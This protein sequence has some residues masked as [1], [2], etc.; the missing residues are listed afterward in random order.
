MSELAIILKQMQKSLE[1]IEQ[2]VGDEM[3]PMTREQFAQWANVSERTVDRWRK[4]GLRHLPGP[5]FTRRWAIEFF[6]TISESKRHQ[7]RRAV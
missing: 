5:L 2:S 3:R 7:L 4:G 6:D 1:A